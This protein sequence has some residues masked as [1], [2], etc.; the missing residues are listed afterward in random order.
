MFFKNYLDT[1]VSKAYNVN[2]S[3][4]TDSQRVS[5][6]DRHVVFATGSETGYGKKTLAKASNYYG[7]QFFL[8]TLNTYMDLQE[9][10]RSAKLALTKPKDF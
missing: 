7:A 8:H 3:E 5:Y 4:V 2:I 1:Q 9:T 6:L 10:Y